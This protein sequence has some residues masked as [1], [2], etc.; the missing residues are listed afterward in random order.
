ME[1]GATPTNDTQ[2]ALA[3]LL[4][5]YDILHGV[6]RHLNRKD[7]QKIPTLC[8]DLRPY[9]LSLYNRRMQLYNWGTSRHGSLDNLKNDPRCSW[10]ELSG[11]LNYDEVSPIIDVQCGE[12][13]VCVL[14]DAGEAYITGVIDSSRFKPT[15][16]SERLPSK[17][18]RL[19]HGSSSI[20]QFSVGPKHIMALAKD[21]SIWRWWSKHETGVRINF[22]HG[23]TDE[24]RYVCTG[25][26]VSSA[27]V[28][29]YGIVVWE[30]GR[31]PTT[32]RHSVL[33]PGSRNDCHFSKEYP[34]P[35]LYSSSKKWILIRNYIVLLDQNDTLYVAR[36]NLPETPQL[37]K[38]SYLDIFEIGDENEPPLSLDTGTAIP[39]RFDIQNKVEKLHGS[40]WS[41]FAVVIQ[42]QDAGKLVLMINESNIEDAIA[43][44]NP[45]HTPDPSLPCDRK[46][47]SL[48]S[49]KIPALNRGG[50]ERTRV[51]RMAF[52]E[53]H[54][55]AVDALGRLTAYGGEKVAKPRRK[56][57]RQRHSGALGLGEHKDLRGFD[58]NIN[59][60]QRHAY[61]TGRQVLFQPSRIDWIGRLN[62]GGHLGHPWKHIRD[63]YEGFYA[64]EAEKELR[65]RCKQCP[66]TR[67][68]VSEWIEEHLNN[69]KRPAASMNPFAV[70]SVAAGKYH[71]AALVEYIPA[72]ATGVDE[73][74]SRLLYPRF[75]AYLQ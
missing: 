1:E 17:A 66:E 28:M 42:S 2:N 56:R 60:L 18:T 55:F 25:W 36:L 20:A 61:V 21:G 23:S 57:N 64:T 37:Y 38:V 34:T 3:A 59:G 51:V 62:L 41:R 27:Y 19:T 32:S 7:I 54:F 13:S 50:N 75:K 24:E 43:L 5:N 8:K 46:S 6:Y 49:L 16:M 58:P 39:H 53:H 14:N 10:P 44:A 47:L 31:V 9:G 11:T 4:Q 65:T 67:G 48:K 72:L 52:G 26:D 70:A 15:P 29:G 63:T 40:Y 35:N 73:Q 68:P 45:G 74:T 22:T 30:T 69:W 12:Y 33:I 71:S